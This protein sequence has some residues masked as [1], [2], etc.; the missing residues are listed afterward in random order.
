MLSRLRDVMN[1][2]E[3]REVSD[4]TGLFC[5]DK[6]LCRRSDQDSADINVIM[7]RMKVG[8]E[9]PTN[10]RVPQYGDFENALSFEESMNAIRMAQV[11]FMAMSG[12]VRAEFGNDPQ[13]FLDFC[14]ARDSD[15]K[16]LNR[17][18]MVK[19]GLAVAPE[20]LPVAPVAPPGAGSPPATGVA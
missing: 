1:E 11:S 14:D 9:V 16:L 20:P 7:E 18:R 6:S 8:Y 12:K 17:D 13:R 15:G 19:L 2:T 5:Q 3:A 10:V 4:A